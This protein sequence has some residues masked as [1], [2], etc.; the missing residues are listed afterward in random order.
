MQQPNSLCGLVVQ[1]TTITAGNARHTTIA[2]IRMSLV[3]DCQAPAC[4]DLHERSVSSPIMLL[5]HCGF[6]NSS[7]QAATGLPVALRDMSRRARHGARLELARSLTCQCLHFQTTPCHLSHS[8]PS[9]LHLIACLRVCDCTVQWRLNG[10]TL[11]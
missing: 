7:C 8:V 4:F 1:I 3:S 6:I 9:L 11:L 2:A 5:F 10:I